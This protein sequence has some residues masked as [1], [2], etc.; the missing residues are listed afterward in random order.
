MHIRAGTPA[1]ELVRV[2][3]EQRMDC[4]IIGSRGYSPLQQLRRVF[5]G[6]IS[7]SILRRSLCPVMVVTHPRPVRPDDLFAWYEA[8]IRQVLVD[9]ST[10]LVNL[11]VHDVVG[12]FLP[13]HGEI[14]GREVWIAAAQALERLESSGLLYRQ[15]VNGEVHY[16]N[17]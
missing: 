4:L 3:V 7:Q 1:D 10:A 13:P 12:L 8:A 2:A 15:N 14:S 11:T 16:L 17:D 5:M 6:S 9:H